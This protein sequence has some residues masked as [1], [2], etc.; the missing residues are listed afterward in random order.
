[1][2]ISEK[3]VRIMPLTM[4]ENNILRDA[5]QHYIDSKGEKTAYG[6]KIMLDEMLDDLMWAVPVVK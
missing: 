6:Q 2:T 3:V 1:M 5:L 4:A